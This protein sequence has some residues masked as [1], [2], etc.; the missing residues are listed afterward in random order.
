VPSFVEQHAA[1]IQNLEQPV[2]LHDSTR[3]LFVDI[4]SQLAFAMSIDTL[5]GKRSQSAED[6]ETYFAV[7]PMFDLAP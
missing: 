5:S 1:I 7:A 4:V 3:N 2:E 6:I